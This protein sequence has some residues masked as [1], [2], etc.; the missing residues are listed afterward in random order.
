M[1]PSLAL[2]RTNFLVSTE[3]GRDGSKSKPREGPEQELGTGRE[4]PSSR[5]LGMSLPAANNR[6]HRR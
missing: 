2:S 1:P 5:S 6:S 3:T 4:G